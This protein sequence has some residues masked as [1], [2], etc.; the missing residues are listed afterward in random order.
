MTAPLDVFIVAGEAS[1]DQLGFK[2]MAALK[3]RTGGKVTFRGVGGHAMAGEGL[4][5]L[6]PMSDISLVGFLA[7]LRHLG[8][9]LSRI[10]ET[11]Q[12]ILKHPP[13]VLVLIDSPDFCHRVARRVRARLPN[14]PIIVYVSPTV[15]AWRPGRA[16]AMAKWCDH[17]LA[18]LPFEPASH[19]ELG[20]PPC[21]YVGHPLIERLDELRPGPA[22][23]AR[24][25]ASPPLILVLPGSRRA[26]LHHLLPVFGEALGLLQQRIGTVELV[27]PTLPHLKAQVEA[28][29]A[30]WPVRPRIVASEADKLTAFRNARAALAASGTVTLE[31]ALAGVPTIAAYRGSAIEAFAARKLIRLHMFILANL[32]LGDIIVPEYLQEDCTAGKLAAAVAGLLA[33]GPERAR[34]LKA[35]A[36]L[37]EVMHV[38]EDSPSR[39]ATGVVIAT[40]ETKTGR[41][42]PR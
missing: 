12:A 28:E 26:E 6:F 29:V 35:F 36:R 11:A 42:A 22:E 1:G 25:G 40:F 33:E 10:D 23:A 38:G 34:Q 30:N 8:R 13:D 4:A 19:R 16:R 9:A 27:L 20:G 21:S 15:W 37:D 39:Q 7:V 24:R 18:L 5:S 3:Q 32:V 17:I 2:L 41:R 14:L 31:L